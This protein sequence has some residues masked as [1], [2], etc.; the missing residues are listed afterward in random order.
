AEVKMKPSKALEAEGEFVDRTMCIGRVAQEALYAYPPGIPL[1]YP[2]ELL[3]KELVSQM[4][5]SR[6]AGIEIKGF[7]DGIG[8]RI[9]CIR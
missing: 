8:E 7:A 2:G 1:V 4:E 3:T 9:L 6:K 5:K